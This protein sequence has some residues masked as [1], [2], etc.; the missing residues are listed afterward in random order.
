MKRVHIFWYGFISEDGKN[1]TMG[2]VQTYLINL[3][4][5]F[6][7]LGYEVHYYRAGLV[8]LEANYYNV[9]VHLRYN[10]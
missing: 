8:D 7:E 2:G 4:K 6:N 3:T 1:V 9:N 10:H 5:V